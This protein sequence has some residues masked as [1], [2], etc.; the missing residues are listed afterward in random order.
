MATVGKVEHTLGVVEVG[1]QVAVHNDG[2]R[3]QHTHKE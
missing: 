2:T 3:Y 1:K